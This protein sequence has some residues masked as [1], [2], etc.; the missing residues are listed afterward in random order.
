MK[1]GRK[2]LLRGLEFN[3]VSL[4][5]FRDIQAV[6]DDAAPFIIEPDGRA[7]H[8]ITPSYLIGELDLRPVKPEHSTLPVVPS[9]V[10]ESSE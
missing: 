5:T 3:Y 8:L 9:P 6:G 1:D 2:E 7:R 10:K 4:R